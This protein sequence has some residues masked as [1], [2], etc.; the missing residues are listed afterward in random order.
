MAVHPVRL[1]RAVV[2]RPAAGACPHTQD[3]SYLDVIHTSDGEWNPSDYAYQLTRRAQGLPLWFSL[4]VYGLEAYRQAIEVAPSLAKETAELIKAAPQL[5]LIREPD[6]GVVLF[7][8]LGWKPEDYDAW[9]QRLH[10]DE[11]AFIP[12]TKWEGETVGRFAF[13]HPDTSLEL[14]REVPRSDAQES[15]PVVEGRGEHEHWTRRDSP[16]GCRRVIANPAREAD[17]DGALGVVEMTFPAGD[18]G[19]PAL[20]PTH[21]EAFYVLAGD[22]SLQ[23]G[24]EVIPVVP[25]RGRAH[26]YVPT[27]ANFGTGEGRVLCPFAPG[28]FERRFERIPANELDEALPELSEAERAT[29]L[30]GPPLASPNHPAKTIRSRADSQVLA[31]SKPDLTR[32]SAT[33]V[34]SGHPTAREC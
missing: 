7:R 11:V 33:N 9:A 19:P 20:R 8:R 31:D 1:L 26:Q 32:R 21:A 25:E 23:V 18:S 16:T 22:L 24:D 10:Q 12:P 15:P 13:L 2:S 30:L 29:Q 17:C 6:L 3:A 27:L 5:E 34:S 14:V 28:G 4:A